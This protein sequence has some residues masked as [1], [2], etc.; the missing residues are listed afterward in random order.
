M[1]HTEPTESPVIGDHGAAQRPAGGLTEEASEDVGQ[2]P[3]EIGKEGVVVQ[4][5]AGPAAQV[6]LPHAAYVD[7]RDA[8]GACIDLN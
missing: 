3:A 2:Q 4:N 8:D 7:G 5:Q 1:A 6:V